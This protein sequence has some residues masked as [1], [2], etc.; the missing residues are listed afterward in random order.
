MVSKSEQMDA[1][2]LGRKLL[3]T[4]LWWHPKNPWKADCRYSDSISQMLTLQA[5]SSPFNA[6]TAKRGDLGR[7]KA[8]GDLWQ[9]V[10]PNGR[11][12]L[13]SIEQA[14]ANDICLA[15]P[16]LQSPAVKFFF[17]VQILGGEKLLK[18]GEK[19]QWNIFKRPERAKNVSNAFRIVFRILFRVFQTVFRIVLKI[20]RRQIRSAR[21]PP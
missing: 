8:L 5:L 12:H 10:P 14:R 6:G 2:G 16:L 13:L 15:W 18:F 1:E 17:F 3:L 9:S 20:F 21:V 7:G 4:P 11:I 19:C